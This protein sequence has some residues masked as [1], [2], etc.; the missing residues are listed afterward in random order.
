MEEDVDLAGFGL[1]SIKIF[2]DYKY[3]N[4]CDLSAKLVETGTGFIE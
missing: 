2:T 3:S 1:F 4:S